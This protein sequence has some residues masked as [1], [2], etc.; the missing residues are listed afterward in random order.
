MRRGYDSARLAELYAVSVAGL[1]PS[2]YTD[3]Y[4]WDVTIGATSLVDDLP[5]TYNKFIR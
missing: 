2:L 4:H 1:V 3:Y 5:C